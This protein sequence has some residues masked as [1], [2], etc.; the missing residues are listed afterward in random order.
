MLVGP[1]QVSGAR[2]DV[3]YPHALLHIQ[4]V[5]ERVPVVRAFT[6]LEHYD[7]LS[8]VL[9]GGAVYLAMDTKNQTLVRGVQLADDTG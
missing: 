2:F 6:R 1:S 5:Q 7:R 3:R 8:S 4:L 9:G